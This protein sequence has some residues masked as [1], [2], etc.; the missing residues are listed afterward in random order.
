MPHNA[1]EAC[2]GTLIS[3]TATCLCMAA[4]MRAGPVEPAPAVHAAL[5][6]CAHITQAAQTPTFRILS[7]NLLADQYAG[8][9]YAQTV[10]CG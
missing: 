3:S 8:S 5:T 6:R 7:Y 1:L 4:N 2:L 9:T 10:G